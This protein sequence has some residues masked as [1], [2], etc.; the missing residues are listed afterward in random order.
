MRRR[1]Y[2]TSEKWEAVNSEN[3]NLL[4]VFLSALRRERCS[5]DTLET[6]E[7]NARRFLVW[8][9]EN[10][11]NKCITELRKKEFSNYSAYVSDLGLATA[12]HNHYVSTVRSWCEHLE[13]DEDVEYDNNLCRK[14]KSLKIERVKQIVFLTDDQVTKLYHELIRIKQYQIA[15]WLAL[16]YDSTGRRMELMQVK[17]EAFF[18]EKCNCTNPVH[19]KG[20]KTEPLIYFERTQEAVKL[21]LGQ[22]SED[23]N[24]SLWADF[25]SRKRGKG[26]ANSWCEHMS[27]ILSV[28]EG[29]K[30]WFTP[31]CLRHSA[32]ENLTEGTHY[33]CEVR[34]I[35][36]DIKVVSKL[37]S[38]ESTEMT[39]YYKKNQGL[40]NI[41]DT[42]GI[43]I[44]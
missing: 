24:P 2:V 12:T 3:K 26:T 14:V 41:A 6:Y 5:A 10:A 39:A 19:K 29:R 44:N 17:K 4:K 32:I 1:Q 43:V 35:P 28:L 30:I 27:K 22:R 37:A 8:V 16:A 18:E 20:R 31:H 7:G 13:D 36:V 11:N 34:R 23:N 38:H 9:L 15:A 40:K 25:Y 42:F 21:W 33:R